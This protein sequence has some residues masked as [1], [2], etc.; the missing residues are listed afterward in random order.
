MRIIGLDL[1]RGEGQLHK[2]DNERIQ[3]ESTKNLSLPDLLSKRI[4][5]NGMYVCGWREGK[6]IMDHDF[7]CLIHKT[8]F[9]Q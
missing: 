1:T 4:I 2:H 7:H 5:Q 3:P 6:G 8:A 9:L